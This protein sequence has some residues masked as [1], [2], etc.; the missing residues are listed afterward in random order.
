M[1]KCKN[2][3]K[4]SYKGTEPS[5]KGLGWCAHAEEENKIR[6]GKDTNK[7]IVKKVSNGSNKWVK[8][9]NSINFANEKV[10]CS[11]FRVYRKKDKNVIRSRMGLKNDETTIFKWISYNKFEK[12]P[13]KIPKGFLEEP[14][15]KKIMNAYYCGDKKILKKDNE[16]FKKIKHTGYKRYYTHDNGGRPFLIYLGKNDAY[17][18]KKSEN[19]YIDNAD[20]KSKDD[21]NKWMYIKLVKKF[22]FIKSFIG[23]SPLNEMTKF[24]RGHGKEFNGNSILLNTGSN[25]YVYIGESI[26]SF[27]SFNNITK[28]VSP[29][30]NNDVPYPYAIDSEQNYYLLIGDVVV[31]NVPKKEDPYEYYY[32]TN[33]ITSDISRNPPIEPFIKNFNNISKFYIGNGQYTMRY[34]PNPAKDYARLCKDIDKNIYILNVDGKKEILTKQKYVKLMADFGKQMGFRRLTTVKIIQKRIW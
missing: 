6:K 11:K 22:K 16:T 34:V 12:T 30:G 20:I 32:R 8:Y 14:V 17:V 1:P 33:K 13:T 5:P 26:F 18:Y 9:T 25:Q 19:I 28:Y 2:D 21:D 31:K 7:W 3:S 27:K 23:K 4:K 29:V 24:K 15:D 10:D